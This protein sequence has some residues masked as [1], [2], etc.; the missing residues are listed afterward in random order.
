MT[1]GENRN[2]YLKGFKPKNLCVFVKV[3]DVLLILVQTALY[4][5]IYVSICSLLYFYEK[6][7]NRMN[8]LDEHVCS[9]GKCFYKICLNKKTTKQFL[10][11]AFE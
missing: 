9:W 4:L 6:I 8:P 1:F 10:V 7:V 2:T 11:Q 5:Y 3:I